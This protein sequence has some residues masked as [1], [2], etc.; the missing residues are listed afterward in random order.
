MTPTE[1]FQNLPFITNDGCYIQEA[2]LSMTAGSKP[3][4]DHTYEFRMQSQTAH[5]LK[6]Q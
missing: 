2:F 5:Y 1:G 6:S 3:V 4:P